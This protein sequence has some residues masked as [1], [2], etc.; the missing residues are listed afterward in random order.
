MVR[1]SDYPEGQRVELGLGQRSYFGSVV[2]AGRR[3]TVSEF[4]AMK[5]DKMYHVWVWWD[6]AQGNSGSWVP[7][8]NLIRL[9]KKRKHGA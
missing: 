3:G 7:V 2:H 1:V 8:K 5:I 4:R 6:T 9:R